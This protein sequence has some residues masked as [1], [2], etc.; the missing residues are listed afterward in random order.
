[1]DAEG[2]SCFFSISPLRDRRVGGRA[3]WLCPSN[4]A[5]RQVSPGATD[6][7]SRSLQVCRPSAKLTVST[8]T[9]YHNLRRSGRFLPRQ[10]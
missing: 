6:L 1:M 5:P 2:R 8:G 3:R 4:V 10:A 7:T 9:D